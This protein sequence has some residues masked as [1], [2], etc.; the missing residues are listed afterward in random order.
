MHYADDHRGFCVKYSIGF[1]GSN[2]K[3]KLLC[4]L[5]PVRYTSRVE[6]ITSKQLLNLKE[7][8]GEL[9]TDDAVRKKVIKSLL[10]KSRFWSYEKEWRVVFSKN[11]CCLLYENNVSFPKIEAI[12]M[13]CR[14]D[15]SIAQLLIKMGEKLDIKIF[16]TMQS[17]SKYALSCYQVN[18]KSNA[19]QAHSYK[20]SKLD[21]IKDE[22]ER[23]EMQRFIHDEFYKELNKS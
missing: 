11:D 16:Q 18:S 19:S 1:A 6:K 20:L 4:S 3:D 10:T 12:Y 9:Y 2:F 22:K 8:E 7:K 21:S 14:I 5:F 15:K 13:G 17:N 23:F